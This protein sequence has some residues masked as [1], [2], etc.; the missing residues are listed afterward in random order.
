MRLP[1]LGL[2]S[3]AGNLKGHTVR[4]ADLVFHNHNN[5]TF[6]EDV[7]E[8]FQ[9]ELVGLSAM[10]FQYS[11]ARRIAQICREFRPDIRIVLGGYHATLIYQEIGSGP[12]KELFDFLV[13]E[14]GEDLSKPP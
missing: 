11:S 9:P 7:L 13:G 5:R 14:R 3:I 8:D 12:D 1:N 2:C 4:I 6:I 10:S